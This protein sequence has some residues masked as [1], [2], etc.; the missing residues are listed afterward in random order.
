MLRRPPQDLYTHSNPQACANDRLTSV[1]VPPAG[2]VI[3]KAASNRPR[4]TMQDN[5]KLPA[6]T[7][8]EATRAF[9]G[10]ISIATGRD[11]STMRY[12]ATAQVDHVEP[13]RESAQNVSSAK[14]TV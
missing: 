8:S 5:V 14:D 13:S 11:S 10:A 3:Y 7:A 6:R 2:G 12:L 9:R 4:R 1:C